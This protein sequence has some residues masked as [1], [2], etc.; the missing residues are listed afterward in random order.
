MTD[1][2][3]VATRLSSLKVE[4]STVLSPEHVPNSEVLA[5]HRKPQWDVSKQKTEQNPKMPNS[6]PA[7]AKFPC[8]KCGAIHFHIDC[9]FREK[10]FFDCKKIGLWVL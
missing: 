1:V 2:V 4:K 9:P 8:R 5:M 6:V 7:K 10:E 3:N